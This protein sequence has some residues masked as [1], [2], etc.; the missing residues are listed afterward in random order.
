MA[1]KAVQG[2]PEKSFYDNTRFIGIIATTD[3]VQE[4]FFKHLVNFDI[5]DTGQ[6]LEPREG[7]L[8][9]T[10]NGTIND[11]LNV[12]TLSNQT[13]VFKD[14]NIN[15][16]IVYDFK[17]NKGYIVDVSAYNIKEKFL[18]VVKII[19]NINWENVLNRLVRYIPWLT[20]YNEIQQVPRYADDLI[21]SE[22]HEGLS[23]N[24]YIEIYNGTNNVVNL[25]IYKLR[26]YANGSAENPVEYTLPNINLPHNKTFI[27][28]NGAIATGSYSF[29]NDPTILK[30]AVSVGVVAFNGNDAIALSKNNVNIDVFGTIGFNP[31]SF[32]SLPSGGSTE[33]SSVFRKPT[34]VKPYNVNSSWNVNEWV[35]VAVPNPTNSG[36]LNQN[37]TPGVHTMNVPY[38]F[39]SLL[40]IIFQQLEILPN[41]K[42]DYIL[43]E[44]GIKKALIKVKL[45]VP[46]ISNFENEKTRQFLLEFY[47]R[48]EEQIINGITYPENT[49]EI[50]VVDTFEHPT[51]ISS[52]R[53]IAVSKSII[54]EVFQ[55]LYTEPVS[56]N[57]FSTNPRPDGHISN[58]GGF[59]YIYDTVL[60][61]VTNFIS[62]S[63]NYTIKPYFDLTPAAIQLNDEYFIVRTGTISAGSNVVSNINTDD[64]RF[65]QLIYGTGIPLN[66]T[67]GAVSSTSFI[68]SSVA[69]ETGTYSFTFILNNA[70][71]AYKI[72]FF[73]TS[74]DISDNIKETV[75]SS[76][77]MSYNNVDAEPTRLFIDS[78][79][80]SQIILGN[81]N[82]NINHYRGSKFVIFVVPKTTNINT[83]SRSFTTLNGSVT[84]TRVASRVGTSTF[85]LEGASIN[86]FLNT[87]N[88][89]KSKIDS[90]KDLKT[91][92]QA[93][94]EMGNTASFHIHNVTTSA[95]NGV[96][97]TFEES[98]ENFSSSNKTGF[99][100]NKTEEETSYNYFLTAEKLLDFIKDNN[101]FK[102]NYS[103]TFKL[104]PFASNNTRTAQAEVNTFS[105]NATFANTTP[106]YF[107]AVP[108]NGTSSNLTVGL[109]TFVQVVNS[110][111]SQHGSVY[112]QTSSTASMSY[113]E[114]STSGLIPSTSFIKDAYY[115]DSRTSKYYLWN[116]ATGFV[117]GFTP[118]GNPTIEVVSYNWFFGSINYWIGYTLTNPD[119]LTKANVNI[120]NEF[121]FYKSID[122]KISLETTLSELKQFSLPVVDFKSAFQF[123]TSVTPRLVSFPPGSGTFEPPGTLLHS[124]SDNKVWLQTGVS[125]APGQVSNVWVDQGLAREFSG[126]PVINLSVEPYSGFNRN[127]VYRDTR[128][129]NTTYR[130]YNTSNLNGSFTKFIN[131]IIN[132]ED[133]GFFDKGITGVFYMKPYNIKDFL[134]EQGVT[135]NF[136]ELETLKT[137]WG[138]TSLTK[139]FNVQ[140]SFDDL[141]SSYIV[142]T[143]IKEPEDIENSENM[144]VF[145]DNQLVKWYKNAL[146]IS[147]PGKYYWF[148]D[149]NK[150][151]FP[152]EIV[153]AL[154]YKTIILVFTT[155]NL[156]AVYRVETTTTQL[157]PATNQIEQNVTGVAWLKQAVLYNLLVNKKYADVI[158]VFNQMVLFYSE[159]GQ[160]FMI[161]P[162]TAIDDQTRFNMQFFN[163][164]A[165]DILLN[166]DVYINE[167]LMYYNKK[168]RVE[169]NNVKIKALVSI[170]YIRIIYYVPNVITYMLIYDVVN[171]R[172]TVYDTLNFTN[173]FDKMFV[174]SGEVFLTEHNNKLYFTFPHLER[175]TK[176]SHIDMAV[177]NNFQKES[178]L[179]LIDTGNLNLN[180]HLTKRLRDLHVVFKNL[181]AENI[182]FNVETTLDDVIAKPFYN[183]QLTVQDIGGISYY[184]PVA[185]IN[186]NELV[187]INKLSETAADVVKY[188]LTNKLFEDNNILLDFSDYN[189]SKLL[190][191]RTSILGMGKVFRIKMQFV[192]KGKYKVQQFGIIYKERRV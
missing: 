89:W 157:N 182:L 52:E 75:F 187:D 66:T 158:Q 147:E 83:A 119:Y 53:N 60:N 27:V 62:R 29:V 136:E 126:G 141:T 192:S 61:Y 138:A 111:L 180:N 50:N 189:S 153:K 10:I 167:R 166:Y 107:N 90:I 161:K 178:I 143:L 113:V 72:E 56:I 63:T 79:R 54:P 176:D 125:P 156:Y 55:N 112:K 120:N 106:Y 8:T 26:L 134:N 95:S 3:P 12:F 116:N 9:T 4:G 171:N 149:I 114:Q 38:F 144:F 47:Y 115:F 94:V 151:E 110:S 82:S 92:R 150:H 69:T 135:K 16:Y 70:K 131:N 19:E 76:P 86:T 179:S 124:R 41:I 11:T 168:E 46:N 73:N 117:G 108:T 162:N 97:S 71:W 104:L 20:E 165:N 40:E 99:F 184:V 170:N 159:D 68:L 30:V 128:N 5:S 109:N 36:V 185:K 49:I 118:V 133:L 175:N 148:K 154:Q 77:W 34:V 32:W 31:G 85:E 18:P 22:V 160:L 188:S 39:S 78:L 137:F 84:E 93:I 129:N 74:T 15:E 44:V 51:F 191:H 173:I 177:Y 14:R 142:K 190:T 48:K 6:S 42:V 2:F 43:D 98:L 121:F 88:N 87:Y 172:Y 58:L 25:N 139:T 67:V 65:G 103:I 164:A 64:I 145:E 186:E 37:G 13:I 1:R 96:L 91:L 130:W 35:S 81:E 23:N 181:N 174:E 28:Y 100:I 183:T 163:K 102:T 101:I 59:V 57:Q 21:I 132:L 123:G 105:S 140:Y 45:N 169:K 24:K 146:Y 122:N 155:Q 80:S 7:F 152:E 127:T 17:N 33:N